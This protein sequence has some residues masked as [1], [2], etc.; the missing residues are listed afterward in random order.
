MPEEHT[1]WIYR[2][3]PAREDLLS[4]GPTEQE[5]A[6]LEAHGEYLDQKAAHG[7]VRL[8]GRTM[9]TDAESFG[10]VVLEVDSEM[11]ARMIMDEDPAVAKGVLVAQLFPFRIAV[12]EG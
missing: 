9:T 3:L 6:I 1:T 4:A 7:L 11:H 10:I 8:A 12:I 2:L 5:A